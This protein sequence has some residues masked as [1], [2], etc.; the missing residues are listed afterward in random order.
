MY[1]IWYPPGI[2]V[3]LGYAILAH[4]FDFLMVK[5]DYKRLL[6]FSSIL[7]SLAI[8]FAFKYF[9]FFKQIFG[10]ESYASDI[11]LPVGISFHAFTAIGYF[12][13]RYKRLIPPMASYTDRLIL[14]VFWPALAAG[15][16]LRATNFIPQIAKKYLPLEKDLWLASLLIAGGAAK[17]LLLSD[18]LGAFVN[19]SFSLGIKEMNALEALVSLIGFSAQIY[20][21]FSGYSDMAL[22]FALFMGYRI[23]ANFNYPYNA[24]SLTDFWRRWH[25]SLSIWFRDYV[26]V[27]LGGARTKSSTHALLNILIVFFLSGIWHGAGYNFI[28]WGLI[29]GGFLVLEK[30]FSKLFF[31]LS[32][33]LRRIITLSVVTLG[34]A[35]FRLPVREANLLIA[36][37]FSPASYLLYS[38][39]SM[40]PILPICCI[41]FLVWIDHFAQYYSV[42]KDGFPFLSR[43]NLSIGFVSVAYIASL[44]LSG[45]TLPFIYF[46][47]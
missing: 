30:I 5:T 15:P 1:T 39:E 23:P 13:D 34:W 26:Y 35:Y 45:N 29:H 25:I 37:I 9:N 41:V 16:I 24:T 17:K 8:L 28:V 11:L 32:T 46:N 22:G 42:D 44:L 21:D 36:K 19:S 4:I 7:I 47:F 10:L 18:N 6:L 3:I 14:M 33:T 12:V 2:L 40:Y 43:K 38:R 27:P 20:V 31:S